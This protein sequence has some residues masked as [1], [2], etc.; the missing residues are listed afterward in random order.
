[1]RVERHW[2]RLPRE[3]WDALFLEVDKASLNEAFD[4]SLSMI[5]G[6]KLDDL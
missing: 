3:I 4:V 5:L 6:V 1:M 2:N